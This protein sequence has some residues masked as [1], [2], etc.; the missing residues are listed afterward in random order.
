MMILMAPYRGETVG[1]ADCAAVLRPTMATTST[2][3]KYSTPPLRNCFSGPGLWE[4]KFKYSW[5]TFLRSLRQFRMCLCTPYT[6]SNG[7]CLKHG[8]QKLCSLFMLNFGHVMFLQYLLDKGRASSMVKVYLAAI[9]ACHI[10]LDLG[11]VGQHPLVCRFL[12]GVQELHPVSKL[13][14]LSWDFHPAG[15]V[16]GFDPKPLSSLLRGST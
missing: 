1:R 8:V 3:A 5:F 2:Q 9:S 12:K 10:G 11:T 13:L 4:I 6:I 15:P 7:E 16:L 14:V